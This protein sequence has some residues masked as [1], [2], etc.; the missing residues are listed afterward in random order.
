MIEILHRLGDDTPIEE[1]VEMLYKH[2]APMGNRDRAEVA[3]RIRGWMDVARYLSNQELVMRIRQM[4]N[5]FAERQFPEE[6]SPPAMPP[7]VRAKKR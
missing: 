6:R 5:R 3:T 1:V 7:I 4:R 2:C